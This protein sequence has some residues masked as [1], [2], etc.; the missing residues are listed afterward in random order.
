LGVP[1]EVR[2]DDLFTIVMVKNV[3]LLFHRLSG[4]FDGIV[5]ESADCQAQQDQVAAP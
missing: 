3:R 5:V 1:V 2:V 4:Q